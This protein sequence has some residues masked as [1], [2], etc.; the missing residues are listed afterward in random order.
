MLDEVKITGAIRDTNILKFKN[1]IVMTGP[2]GYEITL[3]CP[4]RE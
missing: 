4:C 2:E 3:K 1:A